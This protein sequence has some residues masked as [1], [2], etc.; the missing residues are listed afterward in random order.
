MP[1]PPMQAQSPRFVLRKVAARS[2]PAPERD[3][4]AAEGCDTQRG[5]LC[6]ACSSATAP[7]SPI[8]GVAYPKPHSYHV[9]EVQAFPC[10]GMKGG[11]A[12]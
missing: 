6:L 9:M 10:G 12:E 1:Q 3:R 7:A 11:I 4:A 5:G 2:I 8:L